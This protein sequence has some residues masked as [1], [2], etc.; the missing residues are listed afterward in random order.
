MPTEMTDEA[1]RSWWQRRLDDLTRQIEA[2]EYYVPA[3]E[4]AS[5]I[6]FGRPKWGDNP[7]TAGRPSADEESVA[8]R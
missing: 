6:L 3:E 7:E 1:S 5:A 8:N 4:I 2:G